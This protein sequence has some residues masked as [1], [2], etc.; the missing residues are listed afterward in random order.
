V[1]W[2]GSGLHDSVWVLSIWVMMMVMRRISTVKQE[3]ES[4]WEKVWSGWF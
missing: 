1:E 4:V 3:T 2:N